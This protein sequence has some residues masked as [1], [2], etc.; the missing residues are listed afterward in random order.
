MADKFNGRTVSQIELAALFGVAANTVRVWERKGCPAER[1]GVRGQASKYNTAAVIRWREEQAALAASG[2]LAAMD[3][4]EAR[5]RKIVA[6]AA[7]AEIELD[8]KRR[9]LVP[10]ELVGA[11]VEEEY[12]AV[13]ANILALPGEVAADLEHRTASEIEELLYSKVVEILHALSVDGEYAKAP[14]EEGEGG[15]VAPAA[16]AEPRRVGRRVSSD[17]K[18]KQ[19]KSG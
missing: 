14:A 19:R 12:S 16:E 8:M 13:R 18:A 7:S 1:S 2:D 6:E 4:E 11:A 17:R 10:I 9:D 5:R 15:S 3:V